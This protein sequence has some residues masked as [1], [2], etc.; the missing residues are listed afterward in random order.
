MG[1]ESGEKDGVG[2]PELGGD[3]PGEVGIPGR[4]VRRGRSAP[5]DTSIRL[6]LPGQP[7]SKSNSRQIVKIGDRTGIA[8]SDEA[9]GFVEACR[10]HLSS[11]FNRLRL[12]RPIFPKNV[13]VKVTAAIYY[14]SM[15]PDLDE[16]LIL[17]ILQ[18]YAYEN[19]RQVE[20]KDIRRGPPNQF[21][22]SRGDPGTL[23][24]VNEITEGEFW[25]L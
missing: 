13:A 22:N 25:V 24:E 8:K 4:P 19:D 9:I 15:R 2:E 17:D 1:G 23:L 5:V 12:S 10:F 21:D 20:W 11:E 14:E 7:Y 16:A 18:G 3:D 6:W